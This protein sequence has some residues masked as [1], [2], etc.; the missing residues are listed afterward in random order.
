MNHA[1]NSPELWCRQM[2]SAFASPFRSPAPAILQPGPELLGVRYAKLIMS[3][4]LMYQTTSNPLSFW[5]IRSAFES[6]FTSATATIFHAGSTC[7]GSQV[8][9]LPQR[10]FVHR[11]RAE[12]AVR[13]LPEISGVPL[14]SRSPVPTIFHAGS[15][16]LELIHTCSIAVRP[17]ILQRATT[18]SVRRQSRSALRSGLKSAAASWVTVKVCPATVTVP[19]RA[20]PAVLAATLSDTVPPPVPRR[21]RRDRDPARVAR[22]GPRAPGRPGHRRPTATRLPRRRWHWLTARARRPRTPRPA[23]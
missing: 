4:P 19:V 8:P 1:A 11:P 6:E 21:A 2:R 22:G 15:T 18:P 23:G 5:K 7:R 20:V 14:P 3:K 9:P 13:V 12:L 10:A 17:L 16:G